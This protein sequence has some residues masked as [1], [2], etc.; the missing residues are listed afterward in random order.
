MGDTPHDPDASQHHTSLT[1]ED[2]AVTAALRPLQLDGRHQAK[3]A[4]RVDIIHGEAAPGEAGHVH[5]RLA[6]PVPADVLHRE[7]QGHDIEHG[8]GQ[9]HVAAHPALANARHLLGHVLARHPKRDEPEAVD[10]RADRQ[11][12]TRVSGHTGRRIV[13]HAEKSHAESQIE[14]P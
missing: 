3:S 7:R 14:L 11:Q 9:T 1:P 6:V 12:L 2:R 8:D 5:R 4:L 10:E 13:S